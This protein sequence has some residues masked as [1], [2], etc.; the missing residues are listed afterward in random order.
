MAA[1]DD[2][3]AVITFNTMSDNNLVVRFHGGPGI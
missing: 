2:I 1:A 3:A